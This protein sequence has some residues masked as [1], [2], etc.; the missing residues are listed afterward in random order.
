[1][2]NIGLD[3]KTALE[4][5]KSEISDY[6]AGSIEAFIAWIAYIVLVWCFKGVLMFLYGRLT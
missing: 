6:R 1:M 4:V 3:T 2:S 5:P